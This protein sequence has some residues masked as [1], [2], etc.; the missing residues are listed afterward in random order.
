MT[1]VAEVHALERDA[2][3]HVADLDQGSRRCPLAWPVAGLRHSRPAGKARQT[4]DGPSVFQPGWPWPPDRVCVRAR[5]SLLPLGENGA[6][7]DAQL[8]YEAAPGDL[9]EAEELSGSGAR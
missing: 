3:D 1:I 9:G 4:G 5:R 6:P 7:S 2:V 8:R